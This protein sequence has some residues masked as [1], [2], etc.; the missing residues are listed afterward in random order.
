[1]LGWGLFALATA[2]PALRPADRA[3]GSVGLPLRPRAAVPRGDVAYVLLGA[4][5]AISL[6]TVGWRLPGAE[7]ALLVRMVSL[8]GGL[9]VIGA[10]ATAAIA[11]HARR[12]P[13]STRVRLRRALPWM[14]FLGLMAVGAAFV[15]LR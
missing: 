8:V 10:A 15:L 9:A 1:M 7:R 6:Q 11:R 14:V 13:A 3:R 5:L 2:A 4:I 12:A